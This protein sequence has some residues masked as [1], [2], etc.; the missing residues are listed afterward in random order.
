[1]IGLIFSLMSW[2]YCA[3]ANDPTG[4]LLDASGA[5]ITGTHDLTFR[6]ADDQNAGSVLWS[7]THCPVQQRL[8]YPGGIWDPLKS[9][10][11][12]ILR[13]WDAFHSIWKQVD[14]ADTQ[15]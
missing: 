4:S 6:I 7:S 8:L 2:S 13:L 10:T 12:W 1:M 3:A 14:Q 11:H 9:T 15:S 5:A